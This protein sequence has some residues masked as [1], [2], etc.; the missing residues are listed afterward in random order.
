M[1]NH[2]PTN[3]AI[4][5]WFDKILKTHPQKE[6]FYIYT[7]SI[8]ELDQKVTYNELYKKS[9]TIAGN[10]QK[11]TKKDDK[12]LLL[13]GDD[14]AFVTVLL[15]CLFAGRI[16]IVTPVDRNDIGDL[17]LSIGK[18]VIPEH[19]ISDDHEKY[20]SIFNSN[21]I[22]YK[23]IIEPRYT[24]KNIAPR[25]NDIAF[26]Q[27]SSGST[28]Q[29]KGIVISYDNLFSNLFYAVKRYGSE[30][31][32]T[33]CC[34]TPIHH[35][36]GLIGGILLT[37][38][39]G[40]TTI[41]MKPS[42]FLEDPF[43]WLSIISRYQVTFTFSPNFAFDLCLNISG[44]KL[45]ALKL[46]SWML[47]VNGGEG[48]KKETIIEFTEKFAA[49]GLKKYLINP[50]YGLA[51]TTM[52][53][54][55]NHFSE[56]PKWISICRETLQKGQVK[57][58][59][60]KNSTSI[61]VVNCGKVLDEHEIIIADPE[62]REKLERYKTGEIWVRGPSIAQGYWNKQEINQDIFHAKYTGSKNVYFKTG[63]LGFLDKDEAVYILGRTKDML[64]FRGHN[65]YLQDIEQLSSSVCVGLKSNSNAVFS[66]DETVGSIGLIQEV[67]KKTLD[68][69][70]ISKDIRKELAKKLGLKLQYIAFIPEGELPRTALGKIKR[71]AS[72]KLFYKAGNN[73]LY[74]DGG[75]T[76]DK[77]VS[78]LSLNKNKPAFE[79]PIPDAISFL[80]EKN[81]SGALLPSK[82][83]GTG[84]S[85]SQF[86]KILLE[87]AEENIDT[88]SFW[89]NSCGVSLLT[90]I[91]FGSEDLKKELFPLI[92]CGNLLLS[93]A[94]TEDS[95]TG[96]TQTT[97][98][99]TKEGYVI[100]GMK[101]WGGA[102]WAHKA[103]VFAKNNSRKT[104]DLRVFIVDL[105]G[106]NVS[107]GKVY[108]T[109]GLELL[110]QAPINF[111][112]KAVPF[113]Y[114]LIGN[115]LTILDTV[116]KYSRIGVATLCLASIKKSISIAENIAQTKK[117]VAG[118]L[119]EHPLFVTRIYFAKNC[120]R[121]LSVAID[122][123]CHLL[124]N[125][126]EPLPL[127][128]SALLKVQASDWLNFILKELFLSLGSAAYIDTF[129]FEKIFRTSLGF[130]I[131][132]GSNDSLFS[133]VGRTLLESKKFQLYFSSLSLNGKYVS[134]LDNKLTQITK[135]ISQQQKQLYTFYK[136]GK[137]L[138]PFI[139]YLLLHFAK[140]ELNYSVDAHTLEFSE[141][142]SK[143]S[144]E[145]ILESS[146][147]LSL[148]SL[149][150]QSLNK[151][152]SNSSTNLQYEDL[153]KWI[154]KWC[155]NNLSHNILEVNEENDF[156][157][158]GMDS[159][160]VAI[161]IKELN[162]NKKLNLEPSI[163][164]E[165]STIKDFV[166]TIINGA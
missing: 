69:Q 63:D 80:K 154:V 159:L 166:N 3:F 72:K 150:S 163:I 25:R 42:L 145:S 58:V 104:L 135:T 10:L 68:W 105:E 34:W 158:L 144:E 90:V 33:G 38:Y 120:S 46:S 60:E 5:D 47:A 40:A 55:A 28:S 149:A 64:I 15:G 113:S 49:C 17:I 62:T 52:V 83:G 78:N 98:E 121:V 157:E 51:E 8:K 164:W 133:L 165:R 92:K 45:K 24:Y 161:F 147:L 130:S 89:L 12:L 116:L 103:V 151:P 162:E 9:L 66:I 117:S 137:S 19:V 36:M 136:I 84:L 128:F 94:F 114:Q 141:I 140:N 96:I 125:S 88:A 18:E 20:K 61:S 43:N 30:C 59:D 75:N 1:L 16:P 87:V 48:I 79:N 29:P 21:I 132:E 111:D 26:L 146:Q 56:F 118:L 124:E 73:V 85:Y 106:K 50:S 131:I 74:E 44:S 129:E 153:V 155:G 119:H 39:S 152:T 86:L 102:L 37:L 112:K 70:Q 134:M 76:E 65:F 13:L 2:T 126:K 53:I 139:L 138:S 32:K 110:Q 81:L 82:Y 67:S 6:A 35:D 115:G 142:L 57:L 22:D 23:N 143:T 93:F 95:G 71:V 109:M 127:E 148:D 101:R 91:L 108:K 54:T 31:F 107:R 97:F 160:Y 99:K 14:L 77:Y 100:N 11:A 4:S 27:F 156:F 41:L 122:F 7:K 123:I